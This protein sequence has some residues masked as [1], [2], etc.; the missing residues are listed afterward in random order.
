MLIALRR[1][2]VSLI[3]P[4][5]PSDHKGVETFYET[6]KSTKSHIRVASRNKRSQDDIVYPIEAGEDNIVFAKMAIDKMYQKGFF[7]VCTV[8]SC[9]KLMEVRMTSYTSKVYAK[10]RVIHCVHFQDMPE[11]VFDRLP[12]MISEIFLEGPNYP[13]ERSSTFDHN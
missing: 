10:L 1:H 8:D 7:D 6:L 5:A 3:N 13:E 2:L 4:D 12:N 11:G 9:M